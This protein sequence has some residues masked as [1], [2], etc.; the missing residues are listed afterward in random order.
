MTFD[1]LL[2]LYKFCYNFLRNGIPADVSSFQELLSIIIIYVHRDDPS[3]YS[4]N[5]YIFQEKSLKSLKVQLVVS[6]ENFEL[7]VLSISITLVPI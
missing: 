1:I 7:I 4:G 3:F 6:L 2:F 5:L